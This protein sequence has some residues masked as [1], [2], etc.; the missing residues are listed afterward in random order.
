M[1]KVIVII[2]AIS[3]FSIAG[4]A[5]NNSVPFE[6]GL[7]KNRKSEFK[8]AEKQYKEGMEIYDKGEPYWSAAISFL[9]QA[10][11]FNPNNAELNYRL[12]NSFL[13]SSNNKTRSLDYFLKA[14]DLDKNV[15]PDIHF[16]IGRGYQLQ[17][18]F[19]KAITEYNKYKETLKQYQTEENKAVNKQIKECNTAKKMIEKPVRV[20]VENIGVNVN[21]KYADYGPLV[22]ADE[23]VIIFTSRRPSATNKDLIGGKFNED[24]F[25]S[26][27]DINGYWT[28]AVAL[29]GVNSKEHDATA[30]L[31]NDGK[32]LF[33]YK[34][35]P[36]NGGGIYASV[37]KR[38][39][40]SKPKE[41]NKN[42]NGKESWD[43]GASLSYDKKELYFV[44]NKEGGYGKRDIWM[45]RWDE[46]K[47][48]WGKALNIGANINT[49]YDEIGVYM[50]PDGK[51]MYFSSTGHDGM[52]GYDI[53]VSKKQEDGTW[54]KPTNLGYPVNSTD[55]DV[56]FVM[57]ASGK[58]GYYSSYRKDGLGEKDIY[59]LTF[60][61]APKEPLFSTEDNLLVGVDNP[62]EEQLVQAK[63]ELSIANNLTILK[64]V[65][66]DDETK[67]PI[68]ALIELVDNEAQKKITDVESDGKSG[69]FLISLPAGKNYGISVNAEG[70]LFHSENFDIPKSAGFSQFEKK[71]YL[72]KIK[73]GESIV[74]RNIFFDVNK[75]TLKASSVL[76]LAKL[77]DLLNKN[78]SLRVE[79]S[80]HTDTNGSASLNMK[81]SKSRAKAVVDFLI[82][83]GYDSS[84]FEYVGYGEEKPLISDASIAKMTSRKEEEKAHATN[85][86]TEFKILKY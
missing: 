84:R 78:K 6:K 56:H 71:I 40:W 22:S 5:Q 80:G 60:L 55:N 34:T 48:D 2:V 64:G 29:E 65:V 42:I 31:S 32:I 53:Y 11:E 73:I 13:V 50:H 37:Q 83:A 74:L 63:V 46:K 47:Q 51:S 66:L 8:V 85:R 41:L 81:L 68:E 30:G 9:E 20:R 79:I 3:I 26:K 19:D 21:S 18:K 57:A 10:N 82:E 86:R 72:K 7:F 39:E 23:S 70:Y 43:T 4:L 38:G 61:G 58:H 12:G 44:T 59:M 15:A 54:G 17:Y 28:K 52:G 35:T 75:S 27:K 24:V 1:K 45:S 33:V 25:M 76:E 36:N 14:N 16:K 62:H 69:E 49:E 77:A 67:Q